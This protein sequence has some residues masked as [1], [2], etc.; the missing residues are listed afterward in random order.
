TNRVFYVGKVG[1]TV[2]YGWARRSSPGTV[3][4]MP[5]IQNLALPIQ[6]AHQ[7]APSRRALKLLA[8]TASMPLPPPPTPLSRSST[9]ATKRSTPASPTPASSTETGPRGLQVP[10]TF[11]QPHV[12]E[13]SLEHS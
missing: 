12:S 11:V 13:L 9:S 2:K 4:P 1:E 8:T 6:Y 5:R 10:R 7:A 3:G